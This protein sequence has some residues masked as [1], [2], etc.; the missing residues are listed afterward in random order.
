MQN[1]RRRCS[2]ARTRKGQPLTYSARAQL[3]QG[4]R[5]CQGRGREGRAS[6][7]LL[8]RTRRGYAARRLAVTEEFR[9]QPHN[10][11]A[12]DRLDGA[13]E[14]SEGGRPLPAAA[15]GLFEP[16]GQPALLLFVSRTPRLL[17]H[18]L[19]NDPDRMWR[20][21]C[22]C[23]L[24]AK[25]NPDSPRSDAGAARAARPHRSGPSQ[26]GIAGAV[27]EGSSAA[28]GRRSLH[29]TVRAPAGA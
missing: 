29:V 20:G 18:L 16:L 3:R 2:R 1:T 28:P 10:R 9:A 8:W 11:Q 7:R 5:R 23:R 26:P 6:V 27:N 17:R 12:R 24:D 14:S 21:E 22:A 13:S 19:T 25:A 15:V 4:E